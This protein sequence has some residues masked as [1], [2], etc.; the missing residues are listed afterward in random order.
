MKPKTA[1]KIAVDI[2]MTLGLLFLMG[3]QFWQDA[4]HEWA[5][6][7]MFLLFLLHH[8]LN[9]NWYRTLLRGKRSPARVLQLAID[10]LVFLA[11]LGL[12]ASGVILSN[13][14]FG[15]LHIRGGMGF[16]RL[17]HMAA[18]YWGFVL[19]ALHLGLHWGMFLGMARKALKFRPSRARQILLS[20]LGACVAAYG[21]VAFVR[22]DLLTYMLVRTH[23]V[24]FDFREPIPLFYLDYLA[25]MGTCIWIAYYA[26]QFLR[27]WAARPKMARRPTSRGTGRPG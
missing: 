12:M 3:Y 22:R 10:L 4:A 24:F 9:G 1:C 19:M 25:M 6:A 5:G 2:L 26:S 16:A 14:V 17:L 7:G 15:F 23:F 13:H 21:I 20:I 8:V 18:S 11:M 27:K